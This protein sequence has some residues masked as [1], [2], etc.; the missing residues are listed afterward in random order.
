MYNFPSHFLSLT[1][2]VTDLDHHSAKQCM[3]KHQLHI[4]LMVSTCM[5]VEYRGVSVT[6]QVPSRTAFTPH[7]LAAS[8]HKPA[9]QTT[10]SPRHPM[11]VFVNRRSSHVT[12]STQ[13]CLL[14]VHTAHHRPIF[15][16][17]RAQPER[18]LQTNKAVFHRRSTLVWE[19]YNKQ[20]WRDPASCHEN[21]SNIPCVT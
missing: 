11:C 21:A 7:A 10:S 20:R 13:M 3:M 19:G 16:P 15:E 8:T 6:T 18:C 14:L 9:R 1:Q 17:P 4:P 2:A 12:H 5:Q